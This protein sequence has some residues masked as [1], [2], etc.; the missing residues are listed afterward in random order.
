MGEREG[1]RKG[2]REGGRVRRSENG[3]MEGGRVGEREGGSVGRREGEREIEREGG[4][5][6]VRMERWRERE[7][8]ERWTCIPERLVICWDHL[9]DLPPTT[10]LLHYHLHIVTTITLS[11]ETRLYAPNKMSLVMECV[12]RA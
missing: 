7:K 10:P 11:Q 5:E 9:R 6:G 1:G 3:E 12:Q 4:L 2:D 8:R